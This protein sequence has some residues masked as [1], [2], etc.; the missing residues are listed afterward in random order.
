[1]YSDRQ[2]SSFYASSVL[3]N[4]MIGSAVCAAEGFMSETLNAY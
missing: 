1:M 3:I 4:R 2:Q